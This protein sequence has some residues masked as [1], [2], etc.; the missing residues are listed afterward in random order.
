MEFERQFEGV[1]SD[2]E[3]EEIRGIGVA[4][5]GERAVAQ[6]DFAD[7]EDVREL[8]SAEG[9]WLLCGRCGRHCQLGNSGQV[10]LR[11]TWKALL[12]EADA[13]RGLPRRVS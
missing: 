13:R 5:N 9:S 4:S 11:G 10:P 8:Q 2:R 6:V 1:A 12:R 7:F 3:S